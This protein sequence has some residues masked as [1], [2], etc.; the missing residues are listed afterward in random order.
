MA[1][2]GKDSPSTALAG[3]SPSSITGS[4]SVTGILARRAEA[5]NKFFDSKDEG[6][7]FAL[8][9]RLRVAVVLLAAFFA[10]VVF[11]TVEIA[12]AFFALAVLAVL[13]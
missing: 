11:L 4:T 1:R 8:L 5:G 3:H 6:A 12:V 9:T 10:P 7:D 13:A 2:T